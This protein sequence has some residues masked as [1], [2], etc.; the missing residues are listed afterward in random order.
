MQKEGKKFEIVDL[1][2]YKI[3]NR[4]K[5]YDRDHPVLDPAS[6]AYDAHWDKHEK[7]V[8][9][10]YWVD[11]DGT[12]V[13][14][15]P[16]LYYYVNITSIRNAKDGS[17]IKPW[18]RDIE[19]IVF[20]YLLCT[21]GFSGFEGDKEYTC[22]ALVDKLEKGKSID[23]YTLASL[24]DSVL[25]E[26]GTYKKYID[27]WKYLREHYLI[28]NPC[29]Q[30]LGKALY[31]NDMYN[32]IIFS[33]RGVGKSMS[34]F[35]GDFTHEFLFGA[36][37]D[38]KDFHKVHNTMK[39]F[40]GCGDSGQLQKSWSN[41]RSFYYNMP[42][43]FR[44]TNSKGE[45]EIDFG[46]W[47]KN[48]Q[49][50]WT[51]KTGSTIQHIVK[52]KDGSS[53]VIDGSTA[54]ARPITK[55]NLNVSAGD[56][57]RKIYVEEIG[58]LSEIE[59]FYTNN[60]DSMK[61][62]GEKI[63]SFIGLG[64]GGDIKAI[65]K[66]KKMFENPKGYDIYPIPDYWRKSK[67]DCGLFIPA[68]YKYEQFRDNNGNI[69]LELAY[70]KLQD[71]RNQLKETSTSMA[72]DKEVMFNPFEPQEMLIPES[73]GILPLQEVR[74]QVETI[75]TYDL[76]KDRAM[77]GTL[78]YD[79]LSTYGVKF[80]KDLLGVLKPILEW[81]KDSELKDTTGA[82]IMYEQPPERIRDRLY[83][84]V[85][86]PAAKE[87][88]GSSMHSV[89]VY[90]HSFSG[91]EGS[92]QDN[93]VAEWIGRL[94]RLDSN[95][96]MVIRIARFFNARIFPET[97]VAGF[98]KY[99]SQKG[100]YSMLESDAYLLRQEIH[101]TKAL[102]RGYYQ[103]GF[104]MNSQREKFYCLNRLGDWLMQAKRK[105]P[106][107]GVPISRTIDQF[108]SLRALD[109][110]QNYKDDG[111]YDHISSL[112]GLMLLIDKLEKFPPQTR[113]EEDKTINVGYYEPPAPK[114]KRAKI[115]NY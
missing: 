71:E 59:E 64:T 45:E 7:R 66:P 70:A 68:P 65:S 32:G 107:T 10:G 23:K 91:Q 76:F 73:N 26:D 62:S 19:W 31:E 14:M 97:N 94:P 25:K 20:T 85:Y 77:V 6:Y 12:W 82:F 90:K 22:H 75:E 27:P 105:D 16:K 109:E 3:K 11:D 8:I 42:G 52:G 103:V 112:L 4:E 30:P 56:R 93:I 48:V 106:V 72:Y 1:F 13:Y 84:V 38:M 46:P 80:E 47:F 115:L 78:M 74:N 44:F 102:K 60:K 21:E 24:G 55:E 83:Y 63:G 51:V 43:K 81:G 96:D 5:F 95:Y 50:S 28:D 113:S 98:V 54:D 57:Y 39:F 67:K 49:G 110:M 69:D 101:G 41:V 34:V 99:C 108:F 104:Q 35:V 40:L 86:D 88:E 61:V 58:F 37:R 89:L 29:S 92:I 17:M 111:N 9:E 33:G 87:G 53:I 114:Q 100:Y 15:M 36:V 18:L 2:P 79:P